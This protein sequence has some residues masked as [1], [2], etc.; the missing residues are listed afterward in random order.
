[1][2]CRTCHFEK[3]ARSKH[4]KICK[5]CIVRQDHHCIWINNCVGYGNYHWFMLILWSMGI[6]LGY[7]AWLGYTLLSIFLQKRASNPRVHWSTSLSWKEYL[8]V[9]GWAIQQ[10]SRIGAVGLLCLLCLPLVGA[11]ASYH[12]YLIW[13]GMTTNEH[14]KWGDLRDAIYDDRVFIADQ[15][16]VSES[17]GLGPEHQ[18]ATTGEGVWPRYTGKVVINTRDVEEEDSL[19]ED[20]VH[21]NLWSMVDSLR[22]LTNIYDLGFWDNTTDILLGQEQTSR[23]NVRRHL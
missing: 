3:P 18:S 5:V 10:N 13:A 15:K 22:D 12:T 4:C 1:M 9:W 20:L 2:T 16:S 6:L 14:A 11:F 23:R 7:G 21:D 8:S 19:T 17:I